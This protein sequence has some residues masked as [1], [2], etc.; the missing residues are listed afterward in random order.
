MTSQQG[1]QPYAE[2]HETHTG[3]VVLLGDRAFK[4]KKPVDLGFC[5]FRSLAERERIW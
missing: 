3:V 5:D 4:V 1:P 2:L